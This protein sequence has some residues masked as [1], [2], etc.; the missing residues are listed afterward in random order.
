V[1][2]VVFSL[3]FQ[4]RVLLRRRRAFE[5]RALQ[6]RAEARRRRGAWKQHADLEPTSR[7]PDVD[8]GP[9]GETCCH[10]D[11]GLFL[12]LE[13]ATREAPDDKSSHG[14][15]DKGEEE[16]GHDATVW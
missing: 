3:I 1:G 13:V 9:A 4:R 10:F 14:A 11:A 16:L 12:L 15:H 8:K 5:G 2:I 7:W 6:R